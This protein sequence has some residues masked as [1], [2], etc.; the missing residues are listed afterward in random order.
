MNYKDVMLEVPLVAILRGLRPENAIA[1]GEAIIEAGF[2]CI[3]VPLNS[4]NCF[5]SISILSKAYSKR[6]VIGAGTVLQPADVDCVVEAGGTL[7]VSPNCSLDVMRRTKQKGLISMPGVMTPT[8]AFVA[9]ENGADGLKLFPAELLPPAGVKAI[10]T[11]LPKDTDLLPVG[12]VGHSNMG[13]YLQ[14]GATG[15]GFGGSLFNPSLTV[16]DISQR[17]KRIVAAFKEHQRN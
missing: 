4:P 5:E 2:K 9:L 1:T 16:E 10:Q 7:V 14:A 13:E 11:V 12:G 6:A 17:A 8:E 3:E 15:F